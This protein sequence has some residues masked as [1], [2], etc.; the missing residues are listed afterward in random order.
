M[1][2]LDAIQRVT[3]T[4]LQTYTMDLERSTID[5][6]LQ[7]AYI[8]RRDLAHF[9]LHRLCSE[10]HEGCTV[11]QILQSMWWFLSNMQR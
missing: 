3:S 6:H 2:G 9:M 1:Q 11:D 7:W 8:G 5:Q 10:N 4:L